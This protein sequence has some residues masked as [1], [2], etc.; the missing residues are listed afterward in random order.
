VSNVV[1]P[2]MDA[3]QDRRT[4]SPEGLARRVAELE[5]R[6]G[7]FEGRQAAQPISWPDPELI[8][9]GSGTS[10]G[11]LGG[12]YQYYV[13]SYQT[14]ALKAGWRVFASAYGYLNTNGAGTGIVFFGRASA[15]GG[16]VNTYHLEQGGRHQSTTP[17]SVSATMGF[18]VPE[19]GDGDYGMGLLAT[20]SGGGGSI[21]YGGGYYII[22]KS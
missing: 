4:G 13:N 10:V 8:Q 22:Y 12:S 9:W 3:R 11:A 20:N 7:R 18:T 17:L 15:A 6:L 1:M 19:G 14:L 2:G 21:Y 5:R 16:A